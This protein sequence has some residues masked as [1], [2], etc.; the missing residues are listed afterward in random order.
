MTQ[1]TE[2][3][4]PASREMKTALTGLVV[5]AAAT[6][7]LVWVFEEREQPLEP[8]EK[9]A[10]AV[11]FYE[12]RPVYERP[13]GYTKV[14]EGLP[15][16][17]SETCGACHGEIYAEWKLSTHRRAWLDDAQFMEELAKSRGDH[18]GHGEQA[19]DVSW[20][21]VNCHTPLIN[22]LE[23]LVVGLEDGD[24][25]RP[26]YVD[27]PF[28]DPEL[29]LDAIGCATCHVQDG[30]VY[31]PFGDTDAPHPVAKGEFLLDERNCLRCHQAEAMYP[32]RNLG[33]FFTTG[34]EWRNSKFGE[35]GQ[36]C[37]ECHMPSV[38]RK[39]AEAFD[40][41][42]RETRRHWFGGSLIPKHP[43]FAEELEPLKAVFGSGADI[44]V[45]VDDSARC[46]GVEDCL[47]LVV[48]VANA[49]AGHRFPTGDPE[50][51][52]DVDIRA[53]D[54]AGAEVGA[55]SLRI[56]SIYEWW[57]EIRLL[58][59]N[60][61]MP[62]EYHDLVLEIERGRPVH[63]VEVVARKYRMFEEAFDYHKLEGR[64][65]RG[66]TFFEAR[67]GLDE[68]QTLRLIDGTDDR[69]ALSGQAP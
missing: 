49:H 37:Q 13:H 68:G 47:R 29:Q 36:T 18:A 50:R 43:D 42:E 38:T 61:L 39:L 35:S 33:C 63:R 25:G 24:I 27:N 22:Q 15:D 10:K 34:E 56:G 20:M 26:I 55:N 53:V 28:F 30:I 23:R 1:N 7:A 66:R 60:R 62:G 32:E 44:E 9:L 48:R 54:A 17:R 31:G 52:V 14:P 59:D 45:F 6:V 41:P 8:Q 58:S 4:R 12:S 19:S 67:Y 3:A 46:E 51:H 69:G 2:Q 57:P 64:Y 65:V 40:R 5:T 11:A 16:L 21:C